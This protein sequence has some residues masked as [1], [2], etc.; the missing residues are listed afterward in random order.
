VFF[1][2]VAVLGTAYVQ[3]EDIDVGAVWVA[4]GVGALACAILVVNNL[5][6]IASDSAAGKRTLAVVV[7]ERATRQLFI[8]LH[9]A[10]VACAVLAAS[11]LSWWGLLALAALPLS[12]RA[13][14][15]V[16]RGGAGRVLVGALR[17]TGLAELAFAV[18]LLAG[19]ALAAG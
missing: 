4:C 19:L 17:D 1:G 18:G 9:L 13:V 14:R 6:D 11:A 5:R 16:R 2:L 12:W 10:A 3:T 15:I 7:G 8:L